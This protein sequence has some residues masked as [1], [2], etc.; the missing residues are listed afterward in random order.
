MDQLVTE[1]FFGGVSHL[2]S[3]YPLQVQERTNWSVERS[4]LCDCKRQ[5]CHHCQTEGGRA[6]KNPSRQEP[7]SSHVENRHHKSPGHKTK[8]PNERGYSQQRYSP[9]SETVSITQNT[10]AL[11]TFDNNAEASGFA[12][13]SARQNGNQ[14]LSTGTDHY[15]DIPNVQPSTDVLPAVNAH[16][17]SNFNLYFIISSSRI[18]RIHS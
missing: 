12:S 4:Q 1:N 13:A 11:E 10:N 6:R 3:P 7:R 14:L 15:N 17:V 16:M 18:L 9:M 8:K 2:R 5:N